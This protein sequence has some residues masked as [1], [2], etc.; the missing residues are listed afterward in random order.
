MGNFTVT[1]RAAMIYKVVTGS[2]NWH[3]L[4]KIANGEQRYNN[5]SEKTRAQ[6]VHNW[7]RK[8]EIKDLLEL[9]HLEILKKQ[10]VF[11]NEIR[12][13]IRQEE[14]ERAKENGEFPTMEQINYLDRDQFLKALNNRANNTTDE[15]MLNDILKMLSDN[16][17]YKEAEQTEKK[18]I[19]RFYTPLQ[20]NECP[21]YQ[22]EKEL[23]EKA[24]KEM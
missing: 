9:T 20:C 18:E 12:E 21:L 8:S 5:L 14:R 16:M 19:H 4:F 13:K 15:K 17:R 1:E 2:D 23:Q 7:K 11:E 24:K 10:Q 3:D 6:S 22:Q